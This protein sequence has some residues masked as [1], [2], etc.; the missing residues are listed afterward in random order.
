MERNL[1]NMISNPP[2]YFGHPH[3]VLQEPGIT[4]D[5]KRKI[6][7]S[8]KLDAQLLAQ[9]T[10][11]NMTGGEESDLREI[12][13]TLV[14]LNTAEPPVKAVEKTR[15]RTGVTVGLSIGAVAGAGVGLLFLAAS[16]GWSSV[17][18]DG[19][20]TPISVL[21]EA[22]VAGALVGGIIA[23]IRAVSRD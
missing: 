10:A 23:A 12:S 9:S 16:N 22:T 19:W 17:A 5:E 2:R 20:M 18:R 11:E 14:Q 7:E 1:D 15:A 21:I 13:K 3:D 4:T 6:L 8:W